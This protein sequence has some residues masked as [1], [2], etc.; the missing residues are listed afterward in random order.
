MIDSDSCY[1]LM[2]GQCV[3]WSEKLSL[4]NRFFRIFGKLENNQ[5]LTVMVDC[6]AVLILLSVAYIMV[7]L[8]L[9]ICF[10]LV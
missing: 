9:E 3:W 4:V 6:L 10:V 8:L 5:T 1:F 7:Y 2:I